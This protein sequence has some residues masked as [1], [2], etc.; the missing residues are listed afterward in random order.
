MPAVAN[1]TAEKWRADAYPTI[2][3][4]SVGHRTASPTPLRNLQTV[5][6]PWQVASNVSINKDF[7]PGHTLFSSARA[8]RLDSTISTCRARFAY[9]PSGAAAFSAVCWL[10][11][12]EISTE[13][14]P[15]GEV[16]IGLISNNWGGTKVEVWTPASAF[17]KCNRSGDDGP[18][19]NAMILPCKCNSSLLRLPEPQRNRCADATGPMALSGVTW[20][21][22]LDPV[23]HPVV[24]CFRSRD[25]FA[26]AGIKA[27]QTQRTRRPPTSTRACSRR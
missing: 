20:Y 27:R 26:G 8:T 3:F 14:S 19:Y 17:T 22:P 1:A 13:L 12:R 4:F 15:S 25:L 6:E 5:W 21:V 11:G 2:R 23:D 16:P 7:G 9:L 18:M 24:I 10:F